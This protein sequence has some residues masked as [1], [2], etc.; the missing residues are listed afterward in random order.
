MGA[1]NLVSFALAIIICTAAVTALVGH[2]LRPQPAGRLLLSFGLVAAIYGIRMFFKQ[3]LA[4]ALGINSTAALWIES[5]FNYFILIPSLLFVEELYGLGWRRALRWVT[6]GTAAFA[7]AAVIVDLA[8]GDPRYVPDPSLPLM[9][10]VATV[11]L[12]GAVA[13]YKPPRFDEWRI[14]LAGVATFLSFILNEH[15]VGAHVVPWRFSAE[16]IGFLVQLGCFGYIALARVFAQ[17]RQLVAV[18]QEMRSAR[19]IQT[20]ILPHDLPSTGRVRVAARYEPLAAVAGDFYDVVAMEDGAIAVLV[21]DVSGHGIPAALIASMVKVAFAAGLRE[22]RDPAELLQ[23]MNL[24]L[25]GL[26]ERS[27]VTAACALIRPDERVVSYAAAGHPPPLL[28]P[29][30][31]STVLHLEERGLFLGVMPSAAYSTATVSIPS[32]ARLIVYSDGLTETPGPNEELFGIDRL[33][34]FADAERNK[35]PALFADALMTTLRRFADRD[36]LPHDDVT[37]VVVD[38]SDG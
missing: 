3:P 17:E 10:I 8:T 5:G 31:D 11:V 23:R 15:A 26:F 29:G 21:A 1:V 2:V 36:T 38:L 20:S 35:P 22:T 28:V 6:I 19:E 12:V 32:G 27:Y 34:A 7:V 16:P 25:C 9:A 14:L 24:T 18:E 33:T 4:S 37:L 13:G 30:G